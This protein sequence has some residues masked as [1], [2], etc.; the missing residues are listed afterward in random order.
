MNDQKLN[1]ILGE[2]KVPSANAAE[3][4]KYRALTAFDA[5]VSLG[6]SPSINS[7][8]QRPTNVSPRNSSPVRAKSVVL[9]NYAFSWFAF[10][11]ALRL[12]AAT[13][14]AI[15]VVAAIV[16]FSQSHQTD[17]SEKLLA[18]V[19]QLFPDRLNA[20]IERNG[21]AE[22]DLAETADPALIADQP[23]VVKFMRGGEK[24]KVLSFSG[25]IVQLEID[26]KEVTFET[27]VTADGQVIVSGDDFLWSHDN[28]N[29]LLG[30][31]IQ[32]Q[33]LIASL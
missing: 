11:R 19:S 27:L 10:P 21:V 13:S 20:V 18:Q 31:R 2:L 29:P 9:F 24:I 12:C 7:V 28:P 3:R 14:I 16:F 6:R 17:T 33:P 8:G 23:L 25:R 5:S 32:A 22:I 26:G 1:E 30:Y 4:T 15:A